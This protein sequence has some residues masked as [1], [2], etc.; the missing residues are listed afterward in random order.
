MAFCSYCI[1]ANCAYLPPVICE[2][3]LG[4]GSGEVCFPW[5]VNLW[6]LNFDFSV[7]Y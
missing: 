7:K 2:K 5:Q 4:V 1:F 3:E 6:Y